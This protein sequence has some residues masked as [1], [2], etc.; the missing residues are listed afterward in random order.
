MSDARKAARN[1][2]LELMKTC[3]RLKLPFYRFLGPRFA[4]KDAP[5]VEKLPTL[6]RQHIDW[7]C[8]TKVVRHCNFFGD[9]VQGPVHN[10]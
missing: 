2:M 10:L 6:V 5:F 7:V 1:T 9:S 8:R 4:V 3:T